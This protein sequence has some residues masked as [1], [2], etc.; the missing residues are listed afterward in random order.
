MTGLNM[1]SAEIWQCQNYGIGGH[2]DGK[3]SIE[4]SI[5]TSC[6]FL[7]FSGHFD[8]TTKDSL[9]FSG[10]MGNRI[11]TALFYVRKGFV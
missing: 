4:R 2:Y 6:F 5:D 8:F 7:S 1:K 9:P 11:A 3:L 10:G